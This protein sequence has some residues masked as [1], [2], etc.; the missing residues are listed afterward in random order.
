M[1]DDTTS[2]RIAHLATLNAY[3]QSREYQ[4]YACEIGVDVPGYN[5][6]SLFGQR[7]E[8]D[9]GIYNEFLTLHCR[10]GSFFMCGGSFGGIHAKFTE[11]GGRY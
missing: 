1:R 9:E 6:P 8:I 3:R 2:N 5:L 7:C 4:A 10:G 11:E